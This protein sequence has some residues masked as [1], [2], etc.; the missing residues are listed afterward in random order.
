M[1]YQVE[2][3]VARLQQV[4][5]HRPGVEM[6]RLTPGNMGELL[7]DD[8]LWLERAQQEHDQF[9]EALASRGAEVLLLHT[10]LAETMAI[11]EARRELSARVFGPHLLGPAGAE[12]LQQMAA[13]LGPHELADLLV[14]GLTR[15]EVLERI[16]EPAALGLMVRGLDDFVIDPLPNHF[17][18]RDTSCW[19]GGRVQVN[20]MALPARRRE[21]L[22]YEA[23]YRW[24]PR[25]AGTPRWG[26]VWPEPTEGIADGL[27]PDERGALEGG[28][29]LV[30][31]N[32][33]VLVGLG[34]RST[35][36]GAER[37]ARCLFA[38]GA[39]NRVVAVDMPQE[40]AMMH[41][42]T[43]MTM[44]DE[45]SFIRYSGFGDRATWVMTARDDGGLSIESRE[46]ADFPQVLA[47]CL[48]VERVRLLTAPHDDLVA[49]RE[50]W[51][52]ACNVLAL[53]PGV[54]LGYERNHLTRRFLEG[55]GIE[56]IPVPG[57]ELGRGRGG[58]R[59]MTCPT[60][61]G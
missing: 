14:A 25:F 59:C 47:Q 36:L 39:A 54:V 48:G 32:G 6:S 33:S 42:D 18:T 4:I 9:V 3:E 56:V 23:I 7:F 52:D 10:L 43:V 30:V 50:Q 20:A 53:E 2:S 17:F 61:R 41:L 28:D 22:N 21:A 46:P 55:H 51:N 16:G 11:D 57:D 31:G 38:A 34:E 44:L 13:G 45:H 58:P 60:R 15:R 35:P 1:R 27:W 19:V 24:H 37:L 49:Q 5:V 8:I 40:R 12:A 26:G 29:V